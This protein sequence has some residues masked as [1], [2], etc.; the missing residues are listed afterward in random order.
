MAIGKPTLDFLKTEAG[1]GSLLGLAAILA[2]ICANS[3]LSGLY[4]GLVHQPLRLSVGPI[5]HTTGIGEW[6][7][8]GLMAVFF[9]VVGL[10][11]K[12]EVLRGELS[13]P[14]KLALPVVAAIGGMVVPAL[15]Y[16]LINMN[17]GDLRGWSVPVA[18]D[19]AFALAVLAMA[20][21]HLPASLRVFLM[22]LAIVDDLGAVLI[23]GLFYGSGF[24]ALYLGLMAALMGVMILLPRLF[25]VRH[26]GIELAYFALFGLVW[27]LCLNSGLS[28]SLAAVLSAFCVTLK[29]AAGEDSPLKTLMHTLHPSVAYVILPVFAFTAAGVTIG[30]HAWI[31]GRTVIGEES[32]IGWGSILGCDPQDLSF[33]PAADSGVIIG[34]L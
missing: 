3:P 33:D 25:E 4:H 15:I 23:I 24:N 2:M 11:I 22:T 34:P 16:V 5:D 27:L 12:H 8:E 17:G 9:Y 14:K 20:G 1:A 13:D 29:P 7:K 18:T 19:I 6:I 31:S 10:E 32:K 21:P 28:P 26:R 30:G